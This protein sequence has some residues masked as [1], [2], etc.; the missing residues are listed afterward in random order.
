M[1]DPKSPPTLK[2]LGTR[3]TAARG[4][5]RVAG[6]DA[7][8]EEAA[9]AAAEGRGA[10]GVAWR[11]AAELVVAPA[12]GAFAGWWLDHWLSTGPW[13]LLGLFLLGMVAGMY[14]VIRTAGR[15]NRAMT[16]PTSGKAAAERERDDRG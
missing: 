1:S 4:K 16:G 13:F 9:A 15:L 2:D 12:V 7:A 5:R 14:N 11:L 3:L 10:I 6:P 8:D